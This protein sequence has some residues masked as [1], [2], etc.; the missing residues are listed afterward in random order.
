[1]AIILT[2]RAEERK[3][4]NQKQIYKLNTAKKHWNTNWYILK[5]TSN[6]VDTA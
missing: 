3:K 6:E 2:K 1:M 4:E 5:F